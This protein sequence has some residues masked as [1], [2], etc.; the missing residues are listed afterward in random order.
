MV[1]ISDF[2]MLMLKSRLIIATIPLNCSI[3][4]NSFSSNENQNVS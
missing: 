1:R 3:R 4:V 2:A